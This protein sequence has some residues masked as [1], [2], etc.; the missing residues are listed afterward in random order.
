MDLNGQCWYFINR[1]IVT[2]EKQLNS[3]CTQKSVI[4]KRSIDY[5]AR[6]SLSDYTTR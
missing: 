2:S 5:R 6:N 4:D 3:V 1:G